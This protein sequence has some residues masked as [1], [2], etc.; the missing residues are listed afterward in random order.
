[1]SR[2]DLNCVLVEYLGTPVSGGGTERVEAM[3]G[4]DDSEQAIAM[5]GEV[6]DSI[7]QVPSVLYA[8]WTTARV[9]DLASEIAAATFPTLTDESLAAL[10][11]HWAYE[12]R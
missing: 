12:M 5:C 7:G 3:V 4:A 11:A 9:I 6:V 1:M 8:T 2:W 10:R